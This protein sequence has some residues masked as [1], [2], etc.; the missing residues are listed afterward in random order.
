M[1][2]S[3]FLFSAILSIIAQA[4]EPPVSECAV[5]ALVQVHYVPALGIISN[6]WL[7]PST[8]LY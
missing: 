1:K 4:L 8:F 6:G 2:V 3:V 5:P 7:L